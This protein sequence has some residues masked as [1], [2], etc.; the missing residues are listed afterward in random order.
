MLSPSQ[1][2]HR[3]FL[4]RF[5][6]FLYLFIF[7]LHT[8]ATGESSS[9][10]SASSSGSI[11]WTH[12]PDETRRKLLYEAPF[13]LD[14][15]CS[16]L[17]TKSLSFGWVLAIIWR[18]LCISSQQAPWS[19]P[20]GSTEGRVGLRCRGQI[21]LASQPS[22]A[23]IY[24]LSHAHKRPHSCGSGS[25]QKDQQQLRFFQGCSPCDAGPTGSRH[26]KINVTQRLGRRCSPSVSE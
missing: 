3:W 10:L 4:L 21:K 5:I 12:Y 7:C 19:L 22:R 2:H 15:A 16:W 9:S 1:H 17:D 11:L 8:V 18:S 24:C 26:G 20:R 23:P 13:L 25:C 6:Y 14:E